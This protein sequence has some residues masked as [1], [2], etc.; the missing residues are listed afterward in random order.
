MNTGA[1]KGRG[2]VSNA[3]GRYERFRTE[4]FDDGWDHDGEDVLPPLRT[5]V[6]VEKPKSIITRN[7]SPDISFEQSI[8]PYRGCEHGCV[9]CYARPAHAYVGLSPGHDFES[10]LFAKPDAAALLE[11]ELAKPGYKPSPIMLGANT[12]PYQ[13]IERKQRISRSILEVLDSCSHPVAITTKSPNVVRDLDILARMA[14]RNLVSV[15]VSVTTLDPE[16]AR[17]MEP[18]AATPPKRLAAI[19]I[20]R[21]AGVP[22]TLMA[23]PMIPHIND[24]ELEALMDAGAEAGVRHAAYILLR[25]PLEVR[26]LF[27]EWLEAHFPDRRDRVLA[28]V[29]ETRGGR[30]YDPTFGQRMT[31]QGVYADMIRKRFVVKAGQLGLNRA[32]PTEVRLDTSQFTPPELPGS[33]M[34][35]F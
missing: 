13:P 16:L 18:R 21:D 27:V 17:V 2:A 9:Y 7:Q 10:R 33:Q 34:A 5:T 30:D 12:D 19:K 31:G 3:T 32:E 6:T 29:R 35:L 4:A 23:A 20:L 14:S 8:N 15:G 28:Q 11:R 22:V 24:M 26:D 1:I 25:L